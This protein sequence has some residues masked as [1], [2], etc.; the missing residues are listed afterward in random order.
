MNILS[1]DQP[2]RSQEFLDAFH[3]G[4][5][6]TG[7]RRLQLGR[8]AFLYRDKRYQESIKIAHAFADSY[9][10]KAIKY[11]T[12]RLANKQLDEED[13]SGHKYVLLHDMA[14]KTDNR[15]ELPSLIM[16]VFLA[17][18]ESSAITIENALFS[19]RDIRVSGK[20]FA[21]RC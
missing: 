16:H 5:M 6:G 19:F 8:L 7:R 18:H 15:T 20:S 1:P 14:M 2:A 21:K 12:S 11:R 10:D 3:Y 4:Q 17:G 13:K 9:V